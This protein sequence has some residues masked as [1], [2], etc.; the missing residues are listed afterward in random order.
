[1][2]G[3]IQSKTINGPLHVTIGSRKHYVKKIV[4]HGEKRER[5]RLK[6]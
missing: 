6:S 5:R 2:T 4:K 3:R 1:M